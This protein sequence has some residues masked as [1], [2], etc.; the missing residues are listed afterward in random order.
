MDNY[1]AHELLKYLLNVPPTRGSLFSFTQS[2]TAFLQ[3]LEFYNILKPMDVAG[4]EKIHIGAE[5]DGGYVM[6]EP[7]HSGVAYSFGVSSYAPWDLQ[8]A[9]RGFKVFQY[10]GTIANAPDQHENMFFFKFNITGD[11]KPK[12]G[13]TNLAEILKTNA[14][15]DE[16]N[17]ILQIDIEGAEWNFF[18][19]LMEEDMLR[20][21]QI[22]V[23]IHGLKPGDNHFPY[24]LSVLKK[25]LKTHHIIHIHANNYGGVTVVNECIAVPQTLEIS[26]IR[27]DN[28]NTPVDVIPS[29]DHYP[30]ILD[31]PNNFNLP[32]IPLGDFMA[33]AKGMV[34]TKK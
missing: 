16:F 9:N 22:I 19:K 23:E 2:K 20:F 26:F 3:A 17:I 25:I 8:M 21:S 7:G 32:D 15:E 11:D 33:Y 30:T 24:Q 31:Y 13:C 12:P 10:D 27:K 4:L 14:H 5:G 28:F 6:L 29:A 18:A 34:L 1:Y